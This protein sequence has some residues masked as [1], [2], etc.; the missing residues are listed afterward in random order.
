MRMSFTRFMGIA[1]NPLAICLRLLLTCF[2]M[3]A[4]SMAYA[5][6]TRAFGIAFQAN[7]P[8]DILIVGN[9]SMTCSTLATATGA[10]TCSAARAGTATVAADNNNNNHYMTNVVVDPGAPGLNSSSA[11]LPIPPGAAVLWAGLYWGATSGLATR[12]QVSL[13]TPAA[14]YQ[15]LTADWSV[16]NGT[17]YH[18]GKTVTALVSSGGSGSY[19]VADMKTTLNSGYGGWSLVVVYK[20]NSEKYRNLTVFDGYNSVASGGSLPI[21]LSGFK[22]PPAGV[23]GAR[24]GMVAYEGDLGSPGDNM[25]LG[26]TTI[27]D[28]L[29]PSTNLFNSSITRLGTRINDKNPD[30]VNQLGFD[31]DVISADG[32]LPN[33]ATSTVVTLASTGET[34]YPGVITTAIEIY[35]PNLAA[36]LTKAVTDVNGGQLDPGDFLD[37]TISFSNT[38]LDIA[39][40]VFVIDPIPSGT[41][42]VTGTLKILGG[43]NAGA[44]S[45]TGSDDQAE[46]LTGPNRVVFR[47]GTLANGSTGGSLAP[48]ESTTITF[49]VQVNPGTNGTVI[50]NT[51]TVSY[52]SQTL[53]FLYTADKSV[54][55]TVAPLGGGPVPLLTHQKTVQ[56]VSDPIN[57]STNPKNIP[58]A[59]NIYTISVNNTGLGA[60]DTNTLVIVDAVPA[61]SELFTGNFASGAPFAFTDGA[62][63]S[64]LTC[65]F[66]ALSNFTD[67]VDF[68]TDSGATWAYV[69]NGGYDPAVTHL[70]FRLAGAMNADTVAGSPYPG[71]SLQF[72][73]RIK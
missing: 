2:L 58:G 67:C 30:Y 20:L 19:T 16:V 43:A 66:S 62:L 26:T 31:I 59:E 73:V 63:P 33:N 36:S 55:I 39:T 44:K 57:G 21:T 24:V 70:R 41:T 45:D 35:V 51:A 50:N 69:P 1:A 4:F 17:N 46:F 3:S 5:Q 11:G 64:G 72:R 53:G 61:N 47:V 48:G 7:E 28:S 8:G 23:V 13:K 25:K 40:K 9:T 22:T 32:A 68:S 6:T 42:Y 52:N 49:R 29:N 10:V 56:V 18:A 65:P 34:F 15:A 60:A 54:A 27:S 14:G 12:N 37:Y 71:F 38:G